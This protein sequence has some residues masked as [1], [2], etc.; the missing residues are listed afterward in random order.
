M[1]DVDEIRVDESKIDDIENSPMSTATA[2]QRSFLGLAGYFRRFTK[3]FADTSSVLYASMSGKELLI[4][5]DASCMSLGAVIAP[6]K[7]DRKVHSVQLASKIMTSWE[8]K[9]TTCE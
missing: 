1:V 2:E 9:H 7:E 8:M 6:T 3:R 4:W 5:T